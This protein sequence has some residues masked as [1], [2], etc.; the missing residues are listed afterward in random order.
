MRREADRNAKAAAADAAALAEREADAVRLTAVHREAAARAELAAQ[1]AEDTARLSARERA[2]RRV[3]RMILAAGGDQKAVLLADIE[4]E[5]NVG[6]TVASERRQAAAD[7][8]AG[9]YTG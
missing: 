2:E 3:A 5:L 8:I 7:L 9:G 1:E 4:A 6:R